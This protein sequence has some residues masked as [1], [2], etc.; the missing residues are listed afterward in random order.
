MAQSGALEGAVLDA[1]VFV[2]PGVTVEARNQAND[3]VT[4]MFTAGTGRFAFDNNPATAINLDDPRRA[5]GRDGE[6]AERGGSPESRRPPV[7]HCVPTHSAAGQSGASLA[8]ALSAMHRNL[9]SGPSALD[10]I[11]PFSSA[12]R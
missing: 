4:T 12:S 1:K 5:P 9:A 7:A 10:K 2:L 8:T 11:V 3:E 6:A